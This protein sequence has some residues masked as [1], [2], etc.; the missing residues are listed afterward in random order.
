MHFNKKHSP[1]E[2]FEKAL[3]VLNRVKNIMRKEYKEKRAIIERIVR[4][5]MQK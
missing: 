4:E 1:K 5:K 3:V 2:D